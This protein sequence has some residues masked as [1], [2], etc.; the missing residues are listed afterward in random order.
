MLVSSPTMAKKEKKIPFVVI[1]N[2]ILEFFFFFRVP[3]CSQA[4]SQNYGAT[5]CFVFEHR[6]TFPVF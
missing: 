2:G 4:S 6:Q 1:L 5:R 3:V